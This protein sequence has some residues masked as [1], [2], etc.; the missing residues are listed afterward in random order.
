MG[1]P[2]KIDAAFFDCDGVL[3]D[4]EPAAARWNVLVYQ[5]LGVPTNYEENLELIG[6]SVDAIPS[7][8]A[9]HGITI[10]V[11]DYINKAH[12]LVEK[13]EIAENIYLLEDLNLMPGVKELLVHLRERGIKTALVSSSH[14]PDILVLLN[15]F[16]LVSL[17]DA[18]VT[19]DMTKEHKP[20]PAPYLKAMDILGVEPAHS[21]VVEDSPL[22]ISAGVA[23]GAYVLGFQGSE[24]KQDVSQAHEVLASYADFDLI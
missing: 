4:S 20:S 24:V 5:A 19:G 2:E 12:E 14:A 15:R 3:I 1:R 22:G 21:I 13:G 9:K 18:I 23:S 17:F 11:D 8:A 6:Q 16:G 7:L 10:T